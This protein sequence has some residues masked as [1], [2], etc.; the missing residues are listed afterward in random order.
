MA[1]FEIT[2]TGGETFEVDA[3]DENA[4]FRAFQKFQAVPTPDQGVQTTAKADLG[5][6]AGGTEQAPELS[7]MQRFLTDLRREF[8]AIGQG[9]S[10]NVPFRQTEEGEP[11]IEP[12]GELVK[13]AAGDFIRTPQGELI[14]PDHP[15]IAIFTSPEGKQIAF[16]RNEVTQIGGFERLARLFLLGAAAGSPSR[17][18]SRTAENVTELAR[19]QGAQEFGIDLSRG[20]A[21]GINKVQAFEESARQGAKG[22]LAESE[23][24]RFFGSDTVPGVQ[25]TQ[26]EQATESLTQTLGG[27]QQT[28]AFP[29]D[30]AETA[31]ET[32]RAETQRLRQTAEEAFDAVTEAGK[33]DPLTF[34]Q[35]FVQT[36]RLRAAQALDDADLV[37]DPVQHPA[38][39][40]AMNILNELSQVRRTG[41]AIPFQVL[42]KARRQLVKLKA[43]SNNP[44]DGEFLRT[45][46][47]SYTDFLDDAA[48]SALVSGD[49]GIAATNKEAVNFWR[50]FRQI[51]DSAIGNESD[52]VIRKL[53]SPGFDATVDQVSNWL[54]GAT[55]VGATPAAVKTT[56]RLKEI[57]GEGHQAIQDLRQGAFL[58]AVSVP[59]GA[60]RKGPQAMANSL[61]DFL[62]TDLA[63]ELYTGQEIAQ[64]RRFVGVV[65][66]LVPPTNVTNPSRSAFKAAELLR[67]ATTNL[68][69]VLGFAVG[70]VG[71]AILG[72]LGFA[73]LTDAANLFKIK[74][75]VGQQKLGNVIDAARATPVARVAGPAAGTLPQ[76]TA[77]QD[78][79]DAR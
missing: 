2:G 24:S 49:P 65:R 20:Q 11:E 16:P 29:R 42:D 40:Q 17:F 26:V 54:F 56:K 44:G 12:I 66:N 36:V 78:R 18:A 14:D 64:M 9:V 73:P 19:R 45:I 61:N 57:L 13:I 31:M 58:K 22:A 46:R 7:G 50:Q 38:A 53:V 6:E 62:N 48:T 10:P 5:A 41:G 15:D 39:A 52:A 35:D 34:S 69:T 68:A 27:G 28:V 75:S 23:A 30:A 51:T 70:D 72:R 4:A 25:P 32:L 59:L 1:T 3:P 8:E 77:T 55:K 67:G 21:T 60:K 71:G 37:L 76:T 74:Q 33:V 47:R 43:A 79:L 63:K